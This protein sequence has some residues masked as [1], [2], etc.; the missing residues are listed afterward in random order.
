MLLLMILP[1]AFLAIVL[2]LLSFV[3]TKEQTLLLGFTPFS[4]LLA[5]HGGGGAGLRLLAFWK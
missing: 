5:Q 2:H 1:Q 3:K 4:N